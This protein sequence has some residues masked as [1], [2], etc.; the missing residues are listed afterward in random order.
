LSF[1]HYLEHGT[2]IKFDQVQDTLRDSDGVPVRTRNYCFV[3]W[4]IHNASFL[5][6]LS[7]G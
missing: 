7:F 2:L 1:T 6:V 4:C 3:Y 5:F